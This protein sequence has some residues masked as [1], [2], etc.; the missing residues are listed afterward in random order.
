[1]SD[2]E[3]VATFN[4]D[5]LK[6]EAALRK[7]ARAGNAEAQFRL[8]VMHGNGDGVALDYDQARAW[9]RTLEDDRSRVL[10]LNGVPD[11][12]CRDMRE[13][14]ELW[15]YD[16]SDRTPER[17]NVLFLRRSP[18]APYR[19]PVNSTAVS[20]VMVRSVWRSV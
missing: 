17:F 5:Q 19:A 13:P 12:R 1:M 15:Y 6:A 3:T 16:G 8:G 20:T 11:V 9:F 2:Q 18:S 14:R 10:L 4:P 7:A